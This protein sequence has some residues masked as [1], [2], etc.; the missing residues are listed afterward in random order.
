MDWIDLVEDRDK[1]LAFVNAV[2]NRVIVRY[3][4]FLIRWG[5]VSLQRRILVREIS[6][7]GG[8]GTF[9]VPGILGDVW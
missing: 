6:Y 5:A 2:M 4:N 3:K 8:G 7:N 9:L 1:W